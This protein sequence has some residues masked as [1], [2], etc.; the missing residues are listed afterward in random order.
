MLFA[1]VVTGGLRVNG[2]TDQVA[3]LE[4]QE[5]VKGITSFNP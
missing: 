1:A 5:R 4:M 3:E 2:D